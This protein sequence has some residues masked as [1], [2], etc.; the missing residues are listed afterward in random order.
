MTSRFSV[1]IDKPHLCFSAAHFITFAGGECEPLHG[2]DFQMAAEVA[3]PLDDNH[4]VI[5]FV[6]LEEELGRIIGP[7]DHRVLLP[8]QH[9]QIRVHVDADEVT[10]TFAKRRWVFPRED[11]QLLPVANTTSERLAELVVQR[12]VD[13]LQTR[14][15][16][17]PDTV[18]VEIGESGGQAAICDWHPD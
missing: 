14:L 3:G 2:H 4:Y 18:R 6:A 16:L 9:P 17:R 12:L 11:C 1:R 7:W 15:H 8:T 13:A 5:D 10:A